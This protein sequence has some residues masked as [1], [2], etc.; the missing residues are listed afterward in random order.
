MPEDTVWKVVY[1]RKDTHQK[2]SKLKYETEI[3]IQTLAD[4]IISYVLENPDILR[5][6]MLKL[7]PT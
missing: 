2:L 7:K 5:Q 3:K 1:V 4:G 6:V